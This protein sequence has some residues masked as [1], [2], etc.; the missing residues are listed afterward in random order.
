MRDLGKLVVDKGFKKLP[1]VQIIAQSVHTGT[2]VHRI[3][4]P[5][6]DDP[7]GAVW[8]HWNEN[9][10][11]A[12]LARKYKFKI[13][14]SATI[15]MTS[16]WVP[17]MISIPNGRLTPRHFS[18][19]LNRFVVATYFSCIKFKPKRREFWSSGYGRRLVFWKVVGLNLNTR[20]F[21]T[22]ISCKIVMFV[23]WKDQ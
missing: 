19:S 9:A 14:F 12:I 17:P 13:H 21:F 3:C 5:S 6:L 8:W 20:Y 15:S 18:R 1:K 2:S 23:F 22:L 7:F 4:S 11:D 16:L 10:S